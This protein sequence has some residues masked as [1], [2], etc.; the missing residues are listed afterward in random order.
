MILKVYRYV[1]CMDASLGTA[2][3]GITYMAYYIHG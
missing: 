2:S 3:P 1:A